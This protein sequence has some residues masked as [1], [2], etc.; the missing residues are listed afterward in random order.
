VG[1]YDLSSL[2]GSIGWGR[3]SRVGIQGRSGYLIASGVIPELRVLRPELRINGVRYL[4]TFRGV[5]LQ[6]DVLLIVVLQLR[7]LGPEV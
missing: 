5:V 2:I 4:V 7:V 6:V 1:L 3:C